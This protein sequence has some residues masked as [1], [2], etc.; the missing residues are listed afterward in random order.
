M[1]NPRGIADLRHG[2]PELRLEYRLLTRAD[3]EN[4][5]IPQAIGRRRNAPVPASWNS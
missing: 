5:T 3:A 1:N 2:M 4:K